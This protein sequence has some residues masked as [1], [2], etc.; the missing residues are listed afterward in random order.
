MNENENEIINEHDETKNMLEILRNSNKVK[1]K[2]RF[3]NEDTSIFDKES[4]ANVDGNIDA[5][6]DTDEIK[7]VGEGEDAIKVT[8][9]D[10][11]DEQDKLTDIEATAQI[12]SITVYPESNNAV[13]T[14]T[15]SGMND[16]Q[17]QFTLIE[18]DG[19]YI[20]ANSLQLSKD[21]VSVLSKLQGYYSNWSK[22]WAIKI[23]KEYSSGNLKSTGT[24]DNVQ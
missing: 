1:M 11:S 5:N 17:F 18:N 20:T 9:P 16:A 3:L 13:M 4:E 6:V 21:N 8:G 12:T 22:E 24:F 10:L 14:G 23:R 7:D 2:A 15:I 19:C